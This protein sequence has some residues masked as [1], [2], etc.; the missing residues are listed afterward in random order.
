MTFTY[1]H[2]KQIILCSLGL[3]LLLVVVS[4]FIY[5]NFTA[6]DKEDENIVLNTKKDIKKDEEEE[7]ADSDIYYQVDIKG[8]VINPGI[9][10]VKE[11]SRVIDVIRLA[12]DLTEVADTSVLNLSKKVKDEMVIIVYSFDEVLNF[13]ETK[14]KEKIEQEA[15]INQNGITNDACIEDSTDDTSSSSV[16]ISG[17]ISLNTATLDELMMLPGI[18]EAKAEAIIKYREEVGA[19]QNIEELKEVSGIGDAIFDQIKENITI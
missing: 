2:K 3:V 12:G 7:E 6:N 11:G 5:K 14:E 19:F 13:T 16:V 8:E 10:T 18:G 4:I 17:K 1:R 15:C 9:Y